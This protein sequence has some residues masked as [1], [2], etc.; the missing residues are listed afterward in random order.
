MPQDT[1]L[2]PLTPWNET[3]FGTTAS[4]CTNDNMDVEHYLVE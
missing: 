4:I 2:S 1:P 3:M